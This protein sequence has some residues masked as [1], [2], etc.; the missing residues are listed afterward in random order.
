MDLESA[1]PQYFCILSKLLQGDLVSATSI[2][3]ENPELVDMVAGGESLL[4]FCVIENAIEAV[5][6]LLKRGANVEQRQEEDDETPLLDAI[7]LETPE[8]LALLLEHG[9]KSN[10]NSCVFGWAL[11]WAIEKGNFDAVILLLSHGADVKRVTDFDS[12]IAQHFS[13]DQQKTVLSISA[14]SGSASPNTCD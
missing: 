6:F 7:N 4:H 14:V 5:E 8:M 9:A 2:L 1:P 12:L 3:D 11:E 10:V 13:E